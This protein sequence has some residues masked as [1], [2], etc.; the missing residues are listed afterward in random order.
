[1]RVAWDMQ[2]ITGPRPTGLGVSVRLLLDALRE[3]AA[4]VEVAGL[5]PN[6]QDRPLI[7]V[8]DRLAWE[9]W[10]LPRALH[11]EHRRKP[12][13]L[14][15][16]PA[17]GAPLASPVPVLCH[18]HDLIPLHFPEQFGGVAG[19]YFKRLLPYTW[20]RCRA[21]PVSN[22]TVAGDIAEQL[23]FPRERIHVVPYYPDPAVA[24]TAARI[25]PG[26]AA[27]EESGAPDE[28]YFI[29]LASHEP[30][31]NIELAIKALGL[32]D[33]RGIAARLVCIGGHTPHTAALRQLAASC[34]V[35]TAVEFPGYLVQRE[36]VHH[37]LHCTALL[38]VSRYE[39]YGMPPQEA[40][41]VGCAVIL[42]DLA[43]HRHIYGDAARLG[44]LEHEA[45][46][47]PPFVGVEDTEHLASEMQR[48]IEDGA[49]RAKL[50]RA[51][52]A[53][54]K[55]FSPEATAQA[56]KAAFTATLADA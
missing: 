13:S 53:Y 35:S 29:T 31:K 4:E 19:W 41:S 3:Q 6:E 25:K 50:R 56:L 21:L 23:G 28:P 9:Q 17:L 30:R 16:S 54:S 22:A 8:L 10:R 12:L 37:L 18:V 11:R 5:P 36:T 40:Q 43:C 15:Y 24:A 20:R 32:L 27:I 44:K 47:A 26:Y 46:S 7:G 42:S 34:G 38:F 33:Q 39:G 51:G 1:M 49:Y 45:R 55:T 14:A 2:A 52:I 48:L